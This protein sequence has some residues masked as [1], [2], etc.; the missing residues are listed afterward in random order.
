M[1]VRA[2]HFAAARSAGSVPHRSRSCFLRQ[3]SL[4]FTAAALILLSVWAHRTAAQQPQADAPPQESAPQEVSTQTQPPKPPETATTPPVTEDTAV[5]APALVHFDRLPDLP[6]AIGFAGP[7]AGVHNDVLIVAGGA[8]FPK[9]VPWHLTSDGTPSLKVYHDRI[10]ALARDGKREPS[11]YQWLDVDPSKIKLKRPIAYGLSLSTEGGVVC[12]G[13]KWQT[14]ELGNSGGEISSSTYYSNAVFVLKWD[15]SKQSV[16]LS[17]RLDGRVLPPL[18]VG[19]ADMSGAIIGTKGA[20][21]TLYVAG[22]QT[23]AGPTRSFWSLE[24]PKDKRKPLEWKSLDPCPG[25]PRLHSIAV[26]QSDGTDDCVFLFSGRD[27]PAAPWRS[28]TDAYKYC[29]PQRTWSR[30]PDI[31]FADALEPR[32]V[33][34]GMGMAVGAQ[35]ILILGGAEGDWHIKRGRLQQEIAK[36]RAAGDSEAAAALEQKEKDLMDQHGG[37]SPDVLSY[38]TITRQWLRIGRIPRPHGFAAVT[39]AVKWDDAVIVPSGE[40]RPGVRTNLIW[41]VTTAKAEVTFGPANWYV[42]GGYMGLLVLMGLYFSRREKTIADYFL[43]GKRVVWWA[44]GLS[45]FG[46]MLSAITYLSIPARSFGTNWSYAILNMGIPAVAPLVALF[47]LPLFR[48][49]KITTAY[50][51]LEHRFSVSLRLFGSATF[52]VFQLARMSV[53]ILLPALALTAVTGLNVYLCIAVIGLFSTLY[54][55]LGGIEAVIWTDVLQ[56]LV[57]GGGAIIALIIIAGDIGPSRWQGLADIYETGLA[58]DKFDFVH[59]WHAHDLNWARD[60]ILVILLSAIFSTLII[61]SSDQTVIQR[62]LTTSNEKHA[63]WAI[64]TNAVLVI[65][66]TILFFGLGTALFVYYQRNPSDLG[67]IEKPDQIFPWFIAQRL[68]PGIAG[69][70]IAGVFAASMSSLD[71]SMHSVATAITNDFHKRFKPKLSEND[72]LRYAR[73]LTVILGL[74]GTISSLIL[75][76]WDI[77]YLWDVFLKAV[78]LLLGVVAGLFALGIFFNRPTSLH[79]W[80]GTLIAIAVL[81]VFFDKVHGLVYGAIAMVVSVGVGVLSSWILPTGRRPVPGLTI[82]GL[83]MRADSLPPPVPPSE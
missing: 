4:Y 79:A 19:T 41:K 55:V 18:P 48:K 76:D 13:G 39:T 2:I 47:Y 67:I 37:F 8:N 65:P 49:M 52:I 17:D 1:M 9:G 3:T 27:R 50:E 34:A 66:A 24:L 28:F 25:P 71:S 5:N 78:G 80:L 60:G 73:V 14:H 11:L 6:D 12:I 45:I 29:P 77:A 70:V 38:H 15:S 32:C 36:A 72:T 26:A 42:L 16:E 61:Y 54:T 7:F 81:A 35:H 69:L 31:Q 30:L 59:N 40:I 75:V 64:W 58:N 82:H 53:V 62:Y 63:R 43:G 33:M 83:Y 21:R 23:A 44:A 10:F 20:G 57:L 22:G 46:T 74:L 56:V 68:P 51:Y